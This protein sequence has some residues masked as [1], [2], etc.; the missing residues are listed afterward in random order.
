MLK[1]CPGSNE[2]I[3]KMFNNFVLNLKLAMSSFKNLLLLLSNVKDT[4]RHVHLLEHVKSLRYLRRESILTSQNVD[5]SCQN[6]NI[7]ILFNNK[8]NNSTFSI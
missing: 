7:V 2:T 1:Y 4:Q 5:F 8:E 6:V 3:G